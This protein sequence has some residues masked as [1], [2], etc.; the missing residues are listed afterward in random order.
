MGSIVKN[1]SRP[2]AF[3]FRKPPEPCLAESIQDG[4]NVVAV[5]LFHQRFPQ[6]SC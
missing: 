2:L 4:R 6:L 5:T 3:G 1:R